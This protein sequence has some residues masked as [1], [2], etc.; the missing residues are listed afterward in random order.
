MN[1]PFWVRPDPAPS[2]RFEAPVIAWYPVCR[3]TRLRS[4][5]RFPT[6]LLGRKLSLSR[7][8][9]GIEVACLN[10]GAATPAG[11]ERSGLIWVCLAGTHE[12]A[13]PL[14]DEAVV[15]GVS[16]AAYSKVSVKADYDQAVLGLVD[17]AHVPMVHD[18][19]WW[20][21]KRKA[22][23][24]KTKTYKPIPYGFR[25]GAEDA[26]SSAPIYDALGADRHISID[27]ILP[28][29]RLER[30]A[31]GRSTLTSLTTVTPEED[32]AVT[33]RHMLYARGIWLRLVGPVLSRVG[34]AFLKQD[35]RL[36]AQLTPKTPGV[37]Y[38][39]VGDVDQPSAWYFALKVALG[40][41]QATG[42]AFINPVQ[43]RLLRWRT[44]FPFYM[45]LVCL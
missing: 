38:L 30:I 2:G 27:F 21:S 25:A 29:I 32:G 36:L 26:F 20:R 44:A 4:G 43:S 42:S 37:S 40:R 6:R 28:S 33:L 14:P 7:T 19:W 16:L 35:A 5:R 45:S 34:V 3:A 31:T 9:D 23:R 10:D 18:S 11:I 15:N 17:P 39:F 13:P 22:R 12:A 41:A 1:A 8:N 24:V